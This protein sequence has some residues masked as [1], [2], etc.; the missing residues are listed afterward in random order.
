MHRVLWGEGPIMYRVPWSWRA[1]H[2]PCTVGMEGP[3]SIVYRGDG[4]PVMYRV[5]WGR[6]ACHV[7]WMKSVLKMPLTTYP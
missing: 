6:K 7:P 5:P 2:L 3:S 1:C 4:E